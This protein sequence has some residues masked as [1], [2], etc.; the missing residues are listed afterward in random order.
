MANKYVALVS[1]KLKE[2]AAL[3]TSAGAGDANK[4]VALDGNGRLDSSVMPVGYGS[5]TKTIAA[6][7]NL[8]AGDFVNIHVS[9]GL[10]VRKADA[11]GGAA[12]KAHGYVLASVTSGQNATVYYGNINNSVSGFTAGDELYLSASVPGAATTTVPSTAGHIV[13]RLGVATATTEILVELA[14]EVE[15]A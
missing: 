15:I 6:S 1:G 12:K 3:V 2:V 5:E 4:I 9:S 14:Q 10:K 11:S 8:A 7:E 13:Q